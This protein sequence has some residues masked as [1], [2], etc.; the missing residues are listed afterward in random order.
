AIRARFHGVPDAAPG[1]MDCAAMARA[2]WRIVWWLATVMG[3][4]REKDIDDVQSV[5]KHRL[6]QRSPRP[7]RNFR[8][9][10]NVGR[11]TSSR[12]SYA[13]DRPRRWN[14]LHPIDGNTR[15]RSKDDAR[16]RGNKIGEARGAN[17]AAGF[18]AHDRRMVMPMAITVADD[19]TEARKRTA[20]E[21]ILID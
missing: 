11:G 1:R 19:A 16:G 6:G 14:W 9:A 18:S 8:K 3:E 10:T 7:Q 17:N 4:T 5:H 21:D 12:L 2:R 15:H 20:A 13:V